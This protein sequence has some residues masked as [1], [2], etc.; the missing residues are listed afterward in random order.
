MM[1]DFEYFND[2]LANL[3]TDDQEQLREFIQ[4]V[5]EIKTSNLSTYLI[6]IST[7]SSLDLTIIF[8]YNC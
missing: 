4:T 8:R 1:M 7:I 2:L 3:S 6:R 5:A